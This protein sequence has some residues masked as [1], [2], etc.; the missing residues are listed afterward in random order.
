VALQLAVG[1]GLLILVS[2][3]LRLSVAAEATRMAF[4]F[5]FLAGGMGLVAALWLWYFRVPR[6]NRQVVL[7]LLPNMALVAAVGLAFALSTTGFRRTRDLPKDGQPGPGV[8]RGGPRSS[9]EG[10]APAELPALGY[11]PRESN[12]LVG[13]HVA[14]LLRE[15]AGKAFLERPSWG[16]MEAALGQVE[17]WTGLKQEAID[18]IALGMRFDLLVPR[19][20]VAVQTRQPYNPASFAQVLDES[21]PMMHEGRLL[22]PLQIGRF[23]QGIVWC[24]ADR[25]VVLTL[26]GDP[27]RFEEVKAGLPLQPREGTE[28]LS[29]RLGEIV[30]KRLPR[31]ALAW[32]AG[33]NVPEALL[34]GILPFAR[35]GKAPREALKG[36]R[37][38]GMGL[39][40]GEEATLFGDLN[41]R[42]ESRAGGLRELLEGHNVPD[43]GTP[44]V[45][46]SGEWVSFQLRARPE[47]LR[48]ALRSEGKLF[49][50]LGAR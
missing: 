31:G 28:G 7:F 46:A 3:V 12:L 35:S 41:G 49:P 33:E 48:Q 47:V 4:P 10:F 50:G 9:E 36:A 25:T 37:A 20:T 34:S 17:K 5:M 1:S 42:D 11:L 6:S 18:H 26:W 15:P 39:R 32:V 40:F 23:G 16:P 45:V 14:E 13:L 21:K 29:P 24:V 30:Q 8:N 2:L 44:K 22:Y 38:F 19:V 43:I 27:A